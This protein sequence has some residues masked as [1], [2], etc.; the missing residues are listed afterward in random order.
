MGFDLHHIAARH[1]EGFVRLSRSVLQL[2][3][4]VGVETA[5]E[6]IPEPR[7]PHLR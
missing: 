6:V 1:E 7:T 4:D 2:E 3:D 5:D